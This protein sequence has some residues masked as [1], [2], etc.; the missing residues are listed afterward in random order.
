[1]RQVVLDTE[2]TGLEPA[3]GH[4]II[5]IGCVEVLNRRI[6]GVHYHQYLRPD[7][8]IDEGALQVHGI[9]GEYLRDCPRFQDIVG[10]FLAFIKGTELIIHN[11]P[12]DVG[13]ID[14]ELTLL[15]PPAWGR[16]G[17]Y[18]SVVDSLDLARELHPGKRN[19]LDALCGRY[20]IDNS[21]R[22][23]HGALL[24]AEILAEVYLMMT[25]G[26]ADLALETE[27][28]AGA[29]AAVQLSQNKRPPLLVIAPSEEELSLHRQRLQA[30]DEAS[31]GNCLWNI[32]YAQERSRN[33]EYSH[34]PA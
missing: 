29:A 22:E 31:A 32:L 34:G 9:T 27:S 7:R 18:C 11:A 2:T 23:L 4:R 15:P 25:G 1:M 24:D 6:T 3:E 13:F 12:F 10:E 5:E 28:L 30:I 19:T 16:L 20:A 21:K 17:D 8:E 33:E 26:Q 14:H